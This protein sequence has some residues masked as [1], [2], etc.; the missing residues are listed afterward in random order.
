MSFY[1]DRFIFDGTP[2]EA[3]GLI[4]YELD[5]NKQ[6]QSSFV[7]GG[8]FSEDRINRRYDPLFYGA[9]LNGQLTFSMTFGLDPKKVSYGLYF[10]RWD[11]EKIASW[12][13]GKN[14]YRW[15]EI[16]DED[17]GYF[18][19]RCKISDLKIVQAGLYPQ[20]MSCTV[21]CDS[22][23]AYMPEQEYIFN[24]SGTSDFVFHNRSTHNGWY[25]PKVEITLNG[26]SAFSIENLSD[27]NR[28][29][30]FTSIPAG[31]ANATIY[32]D[33][34]NQIIISSSGDNLYPY[35]NKKFFRL[36]RGDNHLKITGTGKLKLIC[37]F[38]V[39]VGG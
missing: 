12:L 2:C 22:P 35:C 25:Y 4:L 11:M 15:L 39:N 18:R 29:F 24:V 9:K 23:Y 26:S 13:T 32:V 16:G 27:E 38:P 20:C 8:E 33:N 1:G 34:Q 19:Y 6:A 37:E 17:E 31:F 21:T 14:G 28:I 10:D 36:V 7:T 3:F 5:S 30:S